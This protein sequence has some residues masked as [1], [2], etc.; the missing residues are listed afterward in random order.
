[1]KRVLVLGVLALAGLM[2]GG[3]VAKADHYHGGGH[4]HRGGYGGGYGGYHRG[5][6]NYAYR[7]NVAIGIGYGA[8]VYRPYYGVG[9]AYPSYGYGAYYAPVYVSGYGGSR[10][11]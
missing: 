10:C 7:P 1:M 9:Y 11:R 8:P 2:T 4:Y 3:S 6:N 5:F